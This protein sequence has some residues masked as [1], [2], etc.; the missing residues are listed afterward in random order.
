MQQYGEANSGTAFF[1][2]KIPSL[3]GQALSKKNNQLEFI[4]SFFA[5]T[6]EP[7]AFDM[8]KA[9]ADAEM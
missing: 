1:K 2:R 6:L 5:E 9:S 3:T 8:A 4:P 7:R